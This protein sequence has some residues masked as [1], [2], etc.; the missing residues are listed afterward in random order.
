MVNDVRPAN[1]QV[2]KVP[3]VMPN[4]EASTAKLSEARFWGSLNLMQAYWHC[5]LAPD[6][7]R[8]C[9]I[10]TPGGLYTPTRVPQLSCLALLLFDSAPSLSGKWP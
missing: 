6:A 3:C 1:Q 7:P 8:I 4:Q 5:S 10:A 9:T 2:E